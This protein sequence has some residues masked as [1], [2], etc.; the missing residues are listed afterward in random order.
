MAVDRFI[1]SSTCI[2]EQCRKYDRY[3]RVGAGAS[4]RARTR[5]VQNRSGAD[6]VS[7]LRLAYGRDV[8]FERAIDAAPRREEGGLGAILC[9]PR[10][11]RLPAAFCRCRSL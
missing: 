8:R 2:S 4:S 9:G 1:V 7:P 3:L 5:S 11:A 10:L 6:R